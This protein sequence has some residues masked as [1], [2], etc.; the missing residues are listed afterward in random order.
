MWKQ[1][2]LDPKSTEVGRFKLSGPEN[3]C[4]VVTRSNYMFEAIRVHRIE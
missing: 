4:G 2:L 3:N 1:I